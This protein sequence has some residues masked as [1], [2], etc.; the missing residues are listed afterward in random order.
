V[1]ELV[2][3]K[4]HGEERAG[5]HEGLVQGRLPVPVV[6]LAA[7]RVDEHLVRLTHRLEALLGDRVIGV[8]VGVA[9]PRQLPG[10]SAS[11]T[12]SQ[13]FRTEKETE[14][15]RKKKK[16]K[17]GKKASRGACRGGSPAPTIGTMS[18][19]NLGSVIQDEKGDSI[20]GGERVGGLVG[21]ALSRQPRVRDGDSVPGTQEKE[22]C[23]QRRKRDTEHGRDFRTSPSRLGLDV[24]CPR[25][26]F[27]ISERRKMDL[28]GMRVLKMGS[29]CTQK[30]ER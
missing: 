16:K 27:T 10:H 29:R 11:P 25:V 8:L 26:E 30:R 24:P 15:E 6:L 17:I 3:A 14:Q 28:E 12:S 19:S 23:I 18:E 21:V 22:K 4:R 1:F 13:S 20:S 7:L 2:R 9:L 5:V